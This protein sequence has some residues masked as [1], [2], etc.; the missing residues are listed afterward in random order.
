MKV[1]IYVEKDVYPLDFAIPYEMFSQAGAE[2]QLVSSK[3]GFITTST[4]LNINFRN[5]LDAV[6]DVD[7]L[8]IC[9]GISESSV[10]DAMLNWFNIKGQN[11]LLCVAVCNGVNYLIDAGLARKKSLSLNK[12]GQKKYKLEQLTPLYQSLVK[13]QHIM[14]LN[15]HG[16]VFRATLLAIEA[17]FDRAV[18]DDIKSYYAIAD[19]VEKISDE[20][21]ARKLSKENDKYSNRY[22][23]ALKKPAAGKHCVLYAYQG[24]AA[25][26]YLVADA[27]AGHIGYQVHRIAD[28]RGV[29]ET[30]R[31]GYSLVVADAI[32]NHRQAQLLVVPSGKIDSYLANQFLVHW[33]SG[34]CT[35]SYRVLTV[36]SAEQLLGVAGL[37]KEIDP[38]VLTNSVPGEGK[39]TLVNHFVA[40]ARA[41]LNIAKSAN[42]KRALLTA[43]HFGFSVDEN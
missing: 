39:Y 10:D 18:L 40:E 3:R 33:F 42:K 15:S 14:T 30:L 12:E 32:Q 16:E 27:F 1:V 35:A 31:G 36:G 34:I 23:K 26:D 22:F 38:D 17:L 29:V 25:I 21:L 37:L 28:Q 43:R 9:G 7:L 5:K 41:L 6:G 19:L 20:R 4:G 24:M 8:W 11:A 2:V 13:D